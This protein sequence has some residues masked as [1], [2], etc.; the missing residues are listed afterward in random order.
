[1][2]LKYQINNNNALRIVN[3]ISHHLDLKG[4][5]LCS[6]AYMILWLQMWLHI[7]E[8]RLFAIFVNNIIFIIV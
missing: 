4:L 6:R 7:N 1:M 2:S 5:T 8:V 3:P